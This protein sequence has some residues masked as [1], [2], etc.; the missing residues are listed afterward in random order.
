MSGRKNVYTGRDNVTHSLLQYGWFWPAVQSCSPPRRHPPCGWSEVRT[1]PHRRFLWRSLREETLQ[2]CDLKNR[3]I[4]EHE[5]EYAGKSF[6][7]ESTNL[8][9]DNEANNFHP[10][11]ESRAGRRLEEIWML[12]SASHICSEFS[13]EP[14]TWLAHLHHCLYSKMQLWLEK[15]RAEHSIAEQRFCPY[16]TLTF[17]RAF[18]LHRNI[19]LHLFSF[20]DRHRVLKPKTGL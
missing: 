12:S 11:C 20:T 14:L 6:T 7:S 4:R 10:R 19:S 1:M 13:W 2:S 18:Q 5:T 16:S 17:L 8:P 15:Q 3:K 9:A